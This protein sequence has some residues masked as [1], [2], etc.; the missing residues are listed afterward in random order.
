MRFSGT[1]PRLRIFAEAPTADAAEALVDAMAAFLGLP[2][3][4]KTG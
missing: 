1:E 4:R 3:A 2:S